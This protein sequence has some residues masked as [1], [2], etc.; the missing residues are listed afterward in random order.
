MAE[1]GLDL[2]LSFSS[3][4]ILFLL[5]CP[6]ACPFMVLAWGEGARWPPGELIAGAMGIR[7]VEGWRMET[8][9]GGKQGVCQ[10]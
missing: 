9:R 1:L 8:D 6:I 5:V 7:E 2:N 3:P 4:R 10:P